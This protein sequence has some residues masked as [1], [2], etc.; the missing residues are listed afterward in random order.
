V[1]FFI[2]VSLFS[3]S[4]CAYL[5]VY[6]IFCLFVMCVCVSLSALVCMPTVFSCPCEPCLCAFVPVSVGPLKCAEGGCLS[7]CIRQSSCHA[8]QTAKQRRGQMEKRVD[9]NR[10][11]RRDS[12]AVVEE[13]LELENCFRQ[14]VPVL[15][16]LR[17]NLALISMTR[18]HTLTYLL[19]ATL[20][21]RIVV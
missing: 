5:T 18:T 8:S 11:R 21:G 1:S 4:L 19:R 17:F 9:E 14:M 13:E 3:S 20:A 15:A 2:S 7:L 16:C 12:E 6:W 10:R